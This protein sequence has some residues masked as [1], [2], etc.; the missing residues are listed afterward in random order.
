MYVDGRKVQFNGEKNLLEVIRKANIDIPTFC[1]HS[2]LSVY[3][4]CRMCLVD[5]EGRGLQSSCSVKP[6]PGIKVK[7][8]TQEVREIRKIAIELLLA[9][10]DHN[11]PTCPKSNSCKLQD[12]ANRLGVNKVRFKRTQ[13]YTDIDFSSQA[14]VRDPNKCILCGDCVRA[15]EELQSIGAIDFAYRGSDVQVL[16]AFGKNLADVECVDCGQCARVCPTGAITPKSEVEEVFSEIDKPETVVVAQVAPAVRVAI[17]ELFGMKNGEIATGQIVAALKLLGFNYVYD[18]SFAAD[19]TVI[20]EATEFLNRKS[21]NEKLP[22]FTSCCP[23]WVRF[24]EQYF[25]NDTKHLSSCRS[26]QQMFGAIG[27]EILPKTLKVDKKNLKIVAI[28]PCTAKK[29]EAR[30]PEFAVDGVRDVDYVLTTQELGLMIKQAG[31]R[32]ESLMPESFD[33]PM[34]FKTGAGIIFGA[35]GGVSEAVLRYVVEKVNGFTLTNVDFTEVRGEESL[36]EVEINLNGEPVKMAIVHG[37]KNA[38]DLM[39]DIKAGKKSYD[40]V[41]V[42]ACPGGCVGGAGQPVCFD[43]STR[44]ER[45]KGLYTSDKMLQLHKP[46]ENPYVAALYESELGEPGSETAHH[47]LHTK[48]QNRKRIDDD[49]L[50]LYTGAAEEKIPVQV[51]IGTSCYLKGSQTLLHKLINHINK[52]DLKQHVDVNATFCME[53]CDRG[54]TVKIGD[55][56]ITKCSFEKACEVLD[57]KLST[58]TQAAE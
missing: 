25:P 16:P 48:Y 39:R 41:E 36:R 2:E 42:M 31:I 10:H 14:L 56:V 55:K 17:G 23:A 5:V 11:C 3:G 29:F 57:G 20:E 21:K 28:M 47:F 43:N 26:P 30:R 15:C 7:T 33:L 52:N 27:K 51:C 24:A 58:I 45:T 13:K 9:N 1:Y 22:I 53:H 34:G 37:L 38:K 44:A 35:S 32:F 19:L 54:P 50:E 8:S 4:A 49:A 46:Q 40:M 18:T 12:I 6:E